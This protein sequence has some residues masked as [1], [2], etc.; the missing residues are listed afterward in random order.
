MRSAG[1]G[2]QGKA[3]VDDK[4]SGDAG[5]HVLSS[6]IR[7]IVLQGC[8]V[9]AGRADLVPGDGITIAGNSE[10]ISVGHMLLDLVFEGFD[11]RSDTVL[12][13]AELFEVVDGGGE[14][15]RC[16]THSGVSFHCL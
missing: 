12:Q 11:L 16:H 6:D 3:S 1:S 4:P 10:H 15:S 8:G 14:F 5:F 2:M 9:K 7:H 13:V